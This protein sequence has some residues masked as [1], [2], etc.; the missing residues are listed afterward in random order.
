M[1]LLR[2]YG[3]S[4][5]P[6]LN[7]GE[8]VVVSE[9]TYDTRPPQRG[10]IVAARPAAFG[11]RALVKRIAALPHERFAYEGREWHLGPDQFFLLSDHLDDSL[12][13]RTL[14]PIPRTALIGPIRFR[15][16]P[17]TKF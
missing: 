17:W 15:L 9:R 1:R 7:A 11:G 13:S 14:G 4:M 10:D 12:D 2:V 3:D 8:L 5:T 16:W 6:T